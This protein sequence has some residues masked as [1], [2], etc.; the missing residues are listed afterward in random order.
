MNTLTALNSFIHSRISA[1]LSPE[2]I[3]WYRR[4]LQ[5]FSTPTRSFLKT[6]RP[7]RIF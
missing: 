5:R 2:T 1:N 6:P 3:D 7:S 4:N